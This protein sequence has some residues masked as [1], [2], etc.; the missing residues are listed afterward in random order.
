[1]QKEFFLVARLSKYVIVKE[2]RGR[3]FMQTQIRHINIVEK[4]LFNTL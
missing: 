1:M 3:I 4:S 2:L